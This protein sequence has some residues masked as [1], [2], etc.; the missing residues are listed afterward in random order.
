MAAFFEVKTFVTNALTAGLGDSAE[1]LVQPGGANFDW[2]V[3]HHNLERA[4]LASHPL[5][6]ESVE[7][8][9]QEPFVDHFV[10]DSAFTAVAYILRT[11]QSGGHWVALLP[12][13]V[14]GLEASVSSAAVLCDSLQPAP[15]I[16]TLTD[17]EDLLTACAME[18]VRANVGFGYDL[19]WGAFL[20]TAPARAMD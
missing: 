16:L 10:R 9:L 4:G 13:R 14:L 19:A 5:P 2:S 8:R 3:L 18:G 15:Y 11:P 12:P 6:P 1:N 17:T 7:S 20:I